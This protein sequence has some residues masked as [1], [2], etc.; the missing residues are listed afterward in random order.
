MTSELNKEG[1]DA[2]RYELAKST[3]RGDKV[4]NAIRAY[5]PFH[6]LEAENKRLR[7]ALQKLD[8]LIFNKIKRGGVPLI[9]DKERANYLCDR[10]NEINNI[11]EQTLAGKEDM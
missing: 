9:S 4:E 5:L 6:P 7:E 3:V 11:V 8:R 1:L 10:I 2:A